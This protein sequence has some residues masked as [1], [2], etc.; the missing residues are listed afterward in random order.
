M[1]VRGRRFEGATEAAAA[2]DSGRTAR[3]WW[4]R[5][6]A[7]STRQQYFLVF[8]SRSWSLLLASRQHWS[9]SRLCETY[10]IMVGNEPLTIC[11]ALSLLC[12][13]LLCISLS[14]N[15]SFVGSRDSEVETFFAYVVSLLYLQSHVTLAGRFEGRTAST[16]GFAV[17]I[18]WF[19]QVMI[20]NA[21]FKIQSYSSQL[22]RFEWVLFYFQIKILMKFFLIF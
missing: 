13:F 4:R 22:Y 12:T 3:Y 7:C 16:I 20:L 10:A 5:A 9:C 6:L 8:F 2:E 18:L 21:T 19:K 11:F 15:S 1:R 17:V 14:M